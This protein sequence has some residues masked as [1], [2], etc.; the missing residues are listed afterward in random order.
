MRI[1]TY[2]NT[3]IH[4]YTHAHIVIV[5]ITHIHT[6]TAHTRLS[7]EVYDNIIRLPILTPP[8]PTKTYKLLPYT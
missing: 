4:T 8:T 7:P 5:H 6:Y 3:H 1:Y 2:T